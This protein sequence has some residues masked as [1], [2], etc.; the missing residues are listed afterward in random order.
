MKK[1]TGEIKTVLKL[2]GITL[3]YQSC[4][5]FQYEEFK[6]MVL[7]FGNNSKPIIFKYLK[8]NPQRDSK[9]ISRNMEKQY[10][11]VCKKGLINDKLEVLPFGYG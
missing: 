11:P 4:Q 7:N 5:K 10:L 8:I 9:V 6:D 3:D 1:E 2:R